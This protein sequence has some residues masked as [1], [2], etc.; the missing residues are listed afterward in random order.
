MVTFMPART[1]FFTTYLNTKVFHIFWE[2]GQLDIVTLKYITVL[3]RKNLSHFF[4]TRLNICIITYRKTST[5]SFFKPQMST[6]DRCIRAWASAPHTR[7]CL[8]YLW[9]SDWLI[10]VAI[11][12]LFFPLSSLAFFE[13]FKFQKKVMYNKR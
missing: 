7:I 1:I 10:L 4:S 13:V 12:L 5:L 11:V 3:Y 9:D 6:L 2:N 8:S